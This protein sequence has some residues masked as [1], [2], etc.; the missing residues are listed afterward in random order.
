MSIKAAGILATSS[1]PSA[2]RA[3][4]AGKKEC[5][6]APLDGLCL[7]A[8]VCSFLLLELSYQSCLVHLQEG[9]EME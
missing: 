3:N 5:A 7:E 8:H 4:T 9:R 6:L 2:G 1:L